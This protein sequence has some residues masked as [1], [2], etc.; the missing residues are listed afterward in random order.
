MP[1]ITVLSPLITQIALPSALRPAAR[2]WAGRRPPGCKPVLEPHRDVTLVMCGFDLDG[3]PVPGDRGGLARRPIEAR[4]F[5]PNDIGLPE[6]RLAVVG[7]RTEAV[8]LDPRSYRRF[9]MIP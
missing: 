8:G 1:S 6:H 5:D 4:G 3:I 9:S 7:D 2:K